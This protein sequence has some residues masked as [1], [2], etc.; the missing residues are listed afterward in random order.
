MGLATLLKGAGYLFKIFECDLIN[1]NLLWCKTA[2]KLDNELIWFESKC[3][4]INPWGFLGSKRPCF[5]SLRQAAA[6][7]AIDGRNKKEFF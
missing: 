1:F 4:T 2:V 6:A 7:A 5:G 3:S